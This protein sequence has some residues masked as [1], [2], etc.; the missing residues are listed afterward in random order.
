MYSRVRSTSD[1]IDNA[2]SIDWSAEWIAKSS[3]EREREIERKRGQFYVKNKQKQIRSC[4]FLYNASTKSFRA[5]V[6]RTVR[7]AS[8]L[9]LEIASMP[10]CLETHRVYPIE[11]V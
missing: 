3:K 7:H 4:A 5:R 2:N 1:N 11:R 8:P 6:C 9:D 10:A